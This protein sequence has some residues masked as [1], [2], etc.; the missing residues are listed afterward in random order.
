MAPTTSLFMAPMCTAQASIAGR[1]IFRAV[2]WAATTW[3]HACAGEIPATASEDGDAAE[4]ADDGRDVWVARTDVWVARTVG[5]SA[6][7]VVVLRAVV[8]VVSL[9][10]R[11]EVVPQMRARRTAPASSPTRNTMGSGQ[12]RRSDSSG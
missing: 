7:G 10:L 12:P 6:V 3:A 9:L 5:W 8:A 1:A 4:A 11:S 2:R